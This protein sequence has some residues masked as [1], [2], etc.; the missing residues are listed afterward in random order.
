[1]NPLACALMS[2]SVVPSSE[3]TDR[4][5]AKLQEYHDEVR[6]GSALFVSAGNIDFFLAIFA[7]LHA[8]PGVP[9]TQLQVESEY[10]LAEKARL[11]KQAAREQSNCALS[12]STGL[13][14]RLL[15]GWAML[16]KPCPRT[17]CHSPLMRDRSGREVCVSCSTPASGR[18]AGAAPVQAAGDVMGEMDMEEED[19]EDRAMLDD[20]AGRIYAEQRMADLTTTA[21]AAEGAIDRVRVKT[22][23]LDTLYRALDVSQQRLRSC[24]GVPADVDEST[25]QATLIAQLAMAARAVCDL[26]TGAPHG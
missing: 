4:L 8:R 23:A 2:V 21:T 17:G 19:E 12:A 7:V 6:Y 24:S 25:R 3:A 20:G 26:P 5:H 9:M 1:M 16:S 13:A 10:E 14:E 15:Q 11:R 18:E 22:Q